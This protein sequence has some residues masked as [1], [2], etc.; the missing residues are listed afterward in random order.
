MLS[1]NEVKAIARSVAKYTYKHFSEAGFSAVQAHR[2][3]KGG[4]KS[5]EVRRQGSVAES[6]PWVAMGISRAT[7]YRRKAAGE[8]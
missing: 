7:Y 2:G 6:Q 8:I 3:R 5:G 1:D 4:I